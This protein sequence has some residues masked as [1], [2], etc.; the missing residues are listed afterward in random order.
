MDKSDFNTEIL[1]SPKTEG[2]S[3]KNRTLSSSS[4][5]AAET[6]DVNVHTQRADRAP[7]N[8]DPGQPTQGTV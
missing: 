6:A 4:G 7:A 2:Q 8:T 1:R 3:K 5:N